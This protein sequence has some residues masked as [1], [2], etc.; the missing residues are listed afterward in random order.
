MPQSGQSSHRHDSSSV[1]EAMNA[2]G[3]TIVRPDAF[4]VVIFSSTV[5]SERNVPMEIRIQ[6]NGS[7]AA[8]QASVD[9]FVGLDRPPFVANRLL[10]AC[11]RPVELGQERLLRGIVHP[12][13]LEQGPQSL[14]HR[15]L[16]VDQREELLLAEARDQVGIS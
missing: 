14:Q 1:Y 5:N 11:Q 9:A 4:G 2:G 15:R 13:R 10:D 6:R 3:L 7:E 16:D 12:L 8:A